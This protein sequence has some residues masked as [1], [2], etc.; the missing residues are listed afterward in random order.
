MASKAIYHGDVL[1]EITIFQTRS[2]N[3]KKVGTI[4]SGKCITIFIKATEND[5]V[6]VKHSTGWSIA[7]INGRENIKLRALTNSETP[8]KPND[9]KGTETTIDTKSDQHEATTIVDTSDE[10]DAN[11][12][13]TTEDASSDSGEEEGAI[14]NERIDIIN[15]TPTTTTTASNK[16]MRLFG[17]PFQ[18]NEYTDHRSSDISNFFGKK[19]AERIVAHAPYITIIPGDADYLGSE[20]GIRKQEDSAIILERIFSDDES[21][22]ISFLDAA[23]NT[24]ETR[25]YN[26]KQNYSGYIDRVNLTLRTMAVMLGLGDTALPVY[27]NGEV[28]NVRLASYD[29]GNYRW[30]A[31]SYSFGNTLEGAL[32]GDTVL[33]AISGA[34]DNLKSDMLARVSSKNIVFQALFS[35]HVNS[36]S[37]KEGEETLEDNNLANTYTTRNYIQFYIDPTATDAT[38][39]F[40]NTTNPS[41]LRDIFESQQSTI[42][43]MAFIANTSGMDVSDFGDAVGDAID[44]AMSSFSGGSGLKGILGRVAQAAGNVIKG[45]N[46]ILPDVYQYSTRESSSKSFKINLYSPYGNPLSIYLNILVPIGFL[47]CLTAPANK[48]A[49][50]YE[51]PPLVKVFYDGVY[52]CS[53]GIVSSLQIVRDNADWTADGLPTSASVSMEIKDLYSSLSVNSASEDV[54]LFMHNSSLIEFLLTQCGLSMISYNFDMKARLRWNT[55]ANLA[56]STTSTVAGRLSENILGGIV[57]KFSNVL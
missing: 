1:R 22:G 23:S 18:F 6:W 15:D 33:D 53:L 48:S 30:D 28:E 46:I 9:T 31:S 16:T 50:S 54:N 56:G 41:K 38:D 26:F 37:D 29:W 42:K 3:S 39:S 19:Y 7:Q 21:N 52:S 45:E 25:Y 13:N 36:S 20:T 27:N 57:N 24:S 55:V 14:K 10:G 12:D 43:E 35:H 40:S 5:R 17:S 8:V 44:E 47:M 32:Q 2:I 51:A 49:N 34:V 4:K 11:D